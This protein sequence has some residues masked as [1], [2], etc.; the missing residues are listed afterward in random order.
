MA[1]LATTMA[2]AKVT[3]ASTAKSLQ[4]SPP[5]QPAMR[6]AVLR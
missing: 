4:T 6:L 3:A 2:R 5:G 1:G